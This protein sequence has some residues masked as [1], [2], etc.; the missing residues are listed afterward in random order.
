[1]LCKE[2]KHYNKCKDQPISM[3]SETLSNM[4][5]ICPEAS[6][7]SPGHIL[8]REDWREYY[9]RNPT[10]FIEEYLDIKLTL[11]QRMLIMLTFWKRGN[12]K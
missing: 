8:L 7:D 5:D 12:K 6:F 9:L 4:E 11:Y 2:C 1:M 3:L 10:R